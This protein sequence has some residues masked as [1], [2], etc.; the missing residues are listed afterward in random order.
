MVEL[1]AIFL[2]AVLV[3]FGLPTLITYKLWSKGKYANYLLCAV[4]LAYLYL[5]LRAFYPDDEFY[6]AHLESISKINF[7]S[8]I[9]V[10][11]KHSTYPDFH[12]DYSACAVFKVS[13]ADASKLSRE[14]GAGNIGG[15]YTGISNNCNTALFASTSSK[16]L[17]AFS[18]ESIGEFESWGYI[19]GSNS[20]FVDA[21]YH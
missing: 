3:L 6:V 4:W 15:T 5:W 1:V 8:Q 21:Y 12:G 9:E 14:S 20:V 11:E 18:T 10:I 2:V 16:I 7:D 19:E 13:E 17:V